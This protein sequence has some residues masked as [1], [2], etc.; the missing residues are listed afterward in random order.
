MN[1]SQIEVHIQ[2]AEVENID[3]SERTLDYC[4]LK[5]YKEYSLVVI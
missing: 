5:E 4:D 1:C 3:Y 2:F